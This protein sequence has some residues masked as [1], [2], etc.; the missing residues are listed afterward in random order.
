MGTFRMHLTTSAPNPS[1]DLRSHFCSNTFRC[2]DDPTARRRHDAS[3][4][5]LRPGRSHGGGSHLG[6]DYALYAQRSSRHEDFDIV[7]R[8][9]AWA[10]MLACGAALVCR[11]E[12]ATVSE[13]GWR[14]GTGRRIAGAIV[15]LG[16][17]LIFAAL[18]MAAVRKL[19]TSIETGEVGEPGKLPPWPLRLAPVVGFALAALLFIFAA[20]RSA[21]ATPANDREGSYDEFTSSHSPDPSRRPRAASLRRIWRTRSDNPRLGRSVVQRPR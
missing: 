14:T 13:P 12:S 20:V 7:H 15:G 10:V 16:S 21:W 6:R 18:A 9:F 1:N 3:R 4:A 19:N 17:A 11:H 5:R 8:D 2:A